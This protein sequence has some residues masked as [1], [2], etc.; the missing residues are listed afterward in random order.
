[1]IYGPK[2]KF[3]NLNT[4]Y[5]HGNFRGGPKNKT[6]LVFFL[7]H[8]VVPLWGVAPSALEIS[9]LRPFGD[10]PLAPQAGG[11][12]QGCRFQG[13][14]LTGFVCVCVV[15]NLGR[16]KIVQPQLMHE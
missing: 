16:R 4:T 5:K 15:Q 14:K 9:H 13:L 11:R 10:G 6:R 7:A 8:G 1:M 12:Q 2:T 3:H